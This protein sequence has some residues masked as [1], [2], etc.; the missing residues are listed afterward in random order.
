MSRWLERF[1]R[2]GWLER[3]GLLGGG[4]VRLAAGAIERTLD[5]AAQIAA[6]AEDAFRKEL[7]PN[8]TDARILEETDDRAGRPGA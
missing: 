4:A 6:D 3:A 8:V 1:E 7:D 5:R 2:A